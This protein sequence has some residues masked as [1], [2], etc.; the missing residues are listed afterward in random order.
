MIERNLQNVT[1]R[2]Y[3]TAFLEAFG[4]LPLTYFGAIGDNLT[5]NY[6]NIQVAIDESIK[7]GL[8]YIF[9]PNG[10]YYYTGTLLNI[11]KI[12]FIGNTKYATIYDGINELPIYQI[13]TQIPFEK[14]TETLDKEVTEDGYIDIAVA[15]KNGSEAILVIG[16]SVITVIDNLILLNGSLIGTNKVYLTDA[17]DNNAYL[18]KIELLRDTIRIYYKITGT[19]G[20]LNAKVEWRV[21]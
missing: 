17:G 11:D 15:T 8:R 10:T 21:R 20:T 5:D 16:S 13:G 12:I 4:M 7:R 6:A 1:I 3:G 14:G 19:G 2:K 18:S 9:V